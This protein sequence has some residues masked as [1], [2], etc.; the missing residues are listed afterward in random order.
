MKNS[1][2]NFQKISKKISCI[3]KEIC[4]QCQ[5]Y[6]KI[7]QIDSSDGYWYCSNCWDEMGI[8]IEPKLEKENSNSKIPKRVPDDTLKKLIILIVKIYFKQ[9]GVF[10]L[11]SNMPE[12]SPIPTNFVRIWE[13]Y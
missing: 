2:R 11:T 12:T 6:S 3:F 8:T 9:M 5:E 13:N 1:T 4:N 7:G 10:F